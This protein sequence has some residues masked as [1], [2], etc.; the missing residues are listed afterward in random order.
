[1]VPRIRSRRP[2]FTNI[3]YFPEYARITGNPDIGP[4]QICRGRNR[5]IADRPLGGRS[6]LLKTLFPDLVIAIVK[7]ILEYAKA[8]LLS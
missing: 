6:I 7:T 5:R 2:P 3:G 4:C 8:A 1:L